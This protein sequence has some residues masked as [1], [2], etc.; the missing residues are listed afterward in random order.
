M[1]IKPPMKKSIQQILKAYYSAQRI[2]RENYW[3]YYYFEKVGIKGLYNIRDAYNN[4]LPGYENMADERNKNI[5]RTISGENHPAYGKSS[6]NK[7]KKLT[8]EHKRKL[9]ENHADVSKEKN[10]FYGR[11]HTIEALEKNRQAHLG[12]ITSNET[13]KKLSDAMKA[14]WAKRLSLS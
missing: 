7:D 11:K 10:P 3:I 4:Y 5:S 14:S 12:K 8:A 6:W 2:E 1:S 9:S 13:K